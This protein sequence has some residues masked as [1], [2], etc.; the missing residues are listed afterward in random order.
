MNRTERNICLYSALFIALMLN[1]ARLL[2]LRQNSVVALYWRFDIVEYAFQ[3][4]YNYF[5]CISL[6]V[7]NLSEGRSLAGYRQN[8]QLGRYYF[9]NGAIVV[10]FILV[11]TFIQY[12]LFGDIGK[13]EALARGYVAR[14][15][16]SA[17]LV[18]VFIRIVLL[19][20]ESKKKDVLNAELRSAHLQSQLALLRSQINPHFLFNS[21]SSLSGI[22]REDPRLAQ[23]YIV[24]L[25]KIFRNNITT[26]KE[27]L[28]SIADELDIVT[29]YAYLLSI[30]LEDA[31]ELSI[32]VPEDMR[33]VR[34]PHLAL[35]TLLENAAK[36]NMATKREPLKVRI[37]TEEKHLVVSNNSHPVTFSGERT[38]TGLAN[39]D[40]RCYLLIGR[41]ITI[42]HT[43]SSF[44]VKLP[45]ALT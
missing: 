3:F 40:E 21:L 28:V 41:H 9:W 39:L 45:L 15:L 27:D 6:F 17:V 24:H 44:T 25:A 18:A 32:D 26:L 16:L 13:K 1:S 20:R 2:A 7:L 11:G 42:T 22:V 30:R 36:H 8:R 10:L 43:Q 5:F 35:Q 4:L 12:R 23:A 31:F 14:F 19:I 29:S 37:Y 38:G 33:Q 34:I